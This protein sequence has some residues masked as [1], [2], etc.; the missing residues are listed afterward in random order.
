MLF[1]E[2]WT[3]RLAGGALAK[4]KAETLMIESVEDSRTMLTLA[5]LTHR[6]AVSNG[7]DSILHELAPKIEDIAPQVAHRL[8]GL[9]T[10]LLLKQS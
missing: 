8:S 2:A 6:S 4:H 5:D 7:A 3:A 1:L 10:D 9:R